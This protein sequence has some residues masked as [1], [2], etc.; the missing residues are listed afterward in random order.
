MFSD[1]SL[2]R[3]MFTKMSFNT[4]HLVS[5]LLYSNNNAGALSGEGLLLPNGGLR[6]A[7]EAA[8]PREGGRQLL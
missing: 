8:Q 5:V 2:R 7:L 3:N 1:G 4:P 6:D